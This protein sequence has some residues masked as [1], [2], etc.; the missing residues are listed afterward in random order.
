MVRKKSFFEKLTGSIKIDDFEGLDGFE[1]ESKEE[2]ESLENENALPATDEDGELPIDMYENSN[3]II[4]K[5]TVA[6]VRPDDLDISI[7]REMVTIKGKR[8]EEKVSQTDS[9]YHRELYWGGF[10]RS[11]MLPQEV[12][13]EEAEAVEKH[14][15]L[16][17]TLPKIN[18]GK[19]T[20]LKVKA[21]S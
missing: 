10:S 16:I 5:T 14:G 18:K 11:I 4:I 19:T 21:G 20:K 1:E 9:S 6:G 15:L 2:E 12:E 3:N 8:E 17:L 7:T 13:V